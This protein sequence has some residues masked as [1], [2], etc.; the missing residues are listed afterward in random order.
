MIDIP[1]NYCLINPIKD[2]DELQSGD[3]K[4][5]IG[6]TPDGIKYSGA[7]FSI[8]RGYLIQLPNKVEVSESG[9]PWFNPVRPLEGNI[10]YFDYLVARD[11]DTYKGHY[12]L[13][14]NSLILE[15]IGDDVKMLNGYM[16]CQNL[17]RT[18]SELD[19]SV[20]EDRFIIKKVGECNLDYLD[21]SID[22]ERIK[23]ESKVITKFSHY[24]NIEPAYQWRLDGNSYTYFMR[25]DVI[26]IL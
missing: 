6:N 20:H 1:K 16:L 13:P 15:V 8:R 18:K 14:Y 24:P 19:D 4:T 21:G 11:C 23:E 25:K 17:P 10:V 9:T 5:K 12:I 22:D 3:F 7:E 26:G 2:N